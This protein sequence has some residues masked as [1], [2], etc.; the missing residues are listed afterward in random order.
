MT[1]LPLTELIQYVEEHVEFTKPI[2]IEAWLEPSDTE[3]TIMDFSSKHEFFTYCIDLAG[4]LSIMDLNEIRA[5][6]L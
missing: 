3:P 2:T 1:H 6:I 4:T 5:R